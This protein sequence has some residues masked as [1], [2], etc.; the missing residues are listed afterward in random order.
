MNEERELHK[1]DVFVR[2][3]EKIGIDITILGN[4]PWIYI[5]TINGKVVKERYMG[6]HGFTIAFLPIRKGQRLE[7]TDIGK[8]FELIRK[9]V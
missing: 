7:F 9:Y 6:D 1:I 3:L 2:R 5:H 4:F 8:I